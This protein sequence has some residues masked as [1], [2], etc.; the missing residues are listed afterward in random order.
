MGTSF[1]RHLG[2]L[3]LATRFFFQWNA[4]KKKYSNLAL[5]LKIM[6]IQTRL[7]FSEIFIEIES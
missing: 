4:K 6:T 7:V 5:I 3:N 1:E 2:F